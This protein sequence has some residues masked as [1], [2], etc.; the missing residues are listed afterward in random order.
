MAISVKNRI[1]DLG[2]IRKIINSSLINQVVVRALNLVHLFV[3]YC[4]MNVVRIYIS[5]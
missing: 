1:S 3:Q 2:N 5:A 4:S